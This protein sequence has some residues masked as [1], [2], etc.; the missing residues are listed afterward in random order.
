MLPWI[1][2]EASGA[3]KEIVCSHTFHNKQ[4]QDSKQPQYEHFSA[5]TANYKFIRSHVLCDPEEFC[6]DWG[7]RFRGL[8]E[9]IGGD[10]ASLHKGMVIRELYD[11]VDDPGEQHTILSE[12]SEI[13][14]ELEARLDAWVEN[15]QDDVSINLRACLKSM[16]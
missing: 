10:T 5:R 4:A 2:G 1:T 12:K 9:R 8:L 7:D 14:T 11:L 13:A 3:P 16:S 15:T 6:H